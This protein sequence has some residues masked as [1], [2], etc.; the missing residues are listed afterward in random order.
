MTTAAR[1][2][3]PPSR[4]RVAPGL[5]GLRISEVARRSGV[6]PKTIRFYESEGIIPPAPRTAAGY[7]LYGENDVRRLRLLRR[8]RGLELGLDAAREV[9]DSAF[10]SECRTYV[11]DLGAMLEAQCAEIDRR[12]AELLALRAELGALATRARQVPAPPGRRVEA[13]GACPIVDDEP[14]PPPGR[15]VSTSPTTTRAPATALR[16]GRATSERRAIAG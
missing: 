11:R 3:A 2:I 6:P 4:T 15:A 7:R 5:E 14:G 10:A 12:V 1:S 16:R 8:L 9:A 13:C